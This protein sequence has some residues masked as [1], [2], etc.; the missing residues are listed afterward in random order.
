MG[1]VAS[2]VAALRQRL[3]RADAAALSNFAWFAARRGE[4]DAALEAARAAVALPNAPRAAWRSLERLAAGRV[5][6]MLLTA[7]GI[8]A[9]PSPR[10]G[11]PLATAHVAHREREF[12]VAE[13]C[14][15]AALDD[16]ALAP[17]ALN[18]M[19]VLHEQRRE[20]A[21]ADEAWRGAIAA[22]SIAAVHNQALALLR[23]GLPHRTRAVLTPWLT[24]PEPA[25]SLQFLAGYAALVDEDPA[26]A[27]PLLTKSVALDPESAR[28]QFSLGLACERLGMHA[29]ALVAIRRALLLSPWYQPQAWLVESGP[30]GPA[31]ELPMDPG[32]GGPATQTDDVL[33]SLGRSLLQTAHLG[34]ALAVFD[35]VLAGH[36]SQTAALFHRGVVLA[37]LRRYDEALE[38]WESVGRVDPG[39]EIG[40]ASRRHARSARQLASLFAG[41]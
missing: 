16:A 23:R 32:E 13:A 9:A 27:L 10:H 17:A 39:S 4:H 38:D 18:G 29:D 33:L 7:G 19:G 8:A 14:Y 37:K 20:R 34:E 40:D 1:S 21:A 24:R 5:D 11:N 22:G 41:A 26:A 15:R 28:A 31:V 25:A 35:Q 36:P 30:D 3:G 2:A 12:A 6:G